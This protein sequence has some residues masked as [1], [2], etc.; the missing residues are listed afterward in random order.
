MT[1]SQARLQS[2]DYK[3]DWEMIWKETVV[4][5][6]LYNPDIWLRGLRKITI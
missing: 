4:A 1:L 3:N 5:K 2:V 6:F